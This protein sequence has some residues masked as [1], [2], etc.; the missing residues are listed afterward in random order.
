MLKQ[1]F[2]TQISICRF[3]VPR[4]DDRREEQYSHHQVHSCGILR[5]SQGQAGSLCCLPRNLSL[6]SG[7]EPGPHRLD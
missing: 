6:H 3:K 7:V 1:S 2:L 4:D 5:F